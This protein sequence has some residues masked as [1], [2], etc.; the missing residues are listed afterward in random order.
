MTETEKSYFFW[1]ERRHN[2]PISQGHQLEK[3]DQIQGR[4]YQHALTER[5]HIRVIELYYP[6]TRRHQ[7]FMAFWAGCY[8]NPVTRQSIVLAL[9][10]A[11]IKP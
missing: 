1:S 4:Y 10:N 7:I 6:L 11:N 2:L 3:I 8:R 5:K 9:I